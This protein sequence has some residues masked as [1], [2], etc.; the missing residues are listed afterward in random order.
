[1]CVERR[2]GH[3]GGDRKGEHYVKIPE[4]ISIHWSVMMDML[5]CNLNTVFLLVAMRTTV[6]PVL[7]S[8]QTAAL[9]VFLMQGCFLVCVHL[10][11]LLSHSCQW[12]VCIQ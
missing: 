6:D 3:G 5:I 7:L 2:A 12:Q 4:N 1:M 10:L 9:R 11:C 8:V